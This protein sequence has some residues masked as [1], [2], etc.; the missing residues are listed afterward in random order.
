MSDQRLSPEAR[1]TLAQQLRASLSRRRRRPLPWTLVSVALV[2]LILTG[3]WYVSR[4][5]HASLPPL[6][7]MCFD[8]LDDDNYRAEAQLFAPSDPDVNLEGLEVHWTVLW[9][10]KVEEA[11]T[12][13]TDRSG[14]ARYRIGSAPTPQQD[15]E[16]I[17]KTERELRV[18]FVD[19]AGNYRRDCHALLFA[20]W[21][22]R[23][24]TL[25]ELIP[26]DVPIPW[27]A[28]PIEELPE[29][30]PIPMVKPGDDTALY[31]AGPVDAATY[32]AMRAWLQH[33]QSRPHAPLPRGPLL[34]DEAEEL[35]KRLR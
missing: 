2:A 8:G 22:P 23:I 35:A 34:R 33:H 19:P 29:P 21:Q 31:A 11:A 16:P 17:K 28:S 4:P 5:T 14:H 12:T 27:T 1:E 30:Q 6:M 25:P 18:S 24:V 10:N 13:K 20:P 15:V 3:L 32:R 7:L 26:G 9:Q